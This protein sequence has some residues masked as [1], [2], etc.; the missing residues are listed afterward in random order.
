MVK[1]KYGNGLIFYTSFHNHA[2][3]SENEKALLQLLLLRQFGAN[4]NSSIE[5]VSSDFGVDIN[6]IKSK[7]D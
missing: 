4:S 7:F 3:A 2:Q 6:V 1:V 5:I